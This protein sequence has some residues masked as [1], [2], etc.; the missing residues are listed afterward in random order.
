MTNYKN[1]NENVKFIYRDIDG[2]RQIRTE[3]LL[4]KIYYVRDKNGKDGISE[5]G[6]NLRMVNT[7]PL[8][9]EVYGEDVSDVDYTRLVHGITFANE[10]GIKLRTAIID[11]ETDDK[12]GFPNVKTA[13]KKILCFVLYDSYEKRY[14]IHGLENVSVDKLIDKINALNFK[15]FV[16][17]REEDM[18]S[19]LSKY[20]KNIDPDLLTGYNIDNFDVPYIINRAKR[21]KVDFTLN[22]TV[23]FDFEAGYIHIKHDEESYALDDVAKKELGY[24]KIERQEVWK[25]TALDRYFYCYWDV[26]IIIELDAKIGVLSYHEHLSVINNSH[27][28]QTFYPT[29]F[30][31]NTMITKVFDTPLKFKINLDKE[32][33]E[34]IDGGLV[35]EPSTG[36][37][38]NVMVFDI[39]GSYPSM[40]MTYNISP[41]TIIYKD[42]KPIGFRTDVK[43]VLPAVIEQ[44]LNERRR[45]KK[46]MKEEKDPIL[47]DGYDKYQ[48]AFKTVTNA[49]YGVFVSVKFAMFNKFLAGKIT[50][51]ARATIM[52]IKDFAETL[53]YIVLYGDTDSIFI[54]AK[55]KNITEEGKELA[56]KINDYI[57]EERKKQGLVNYT[58]IEFEKVFTKWLQTG[59]KKRYAGIY[60]KDNGEDELLIK[61]YE[62]RR[63]GNS[64]YTKITQ[65]EFIRLLLTDVALAKK[66]YKEEE[67]KWNEEKVSVYKIAINYAMRNN[68]EEYTTNLPVIRA[69]KNSRRK[70]I[71]I[72]ENLGR[73]WVYYLKNGEE[74]AFT[75]NSE[76]PHKLPID[77]KLHKDKCFTS[78][79]ESLY[80]LIG[81][82]TSL[83][84]FFE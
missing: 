25:M 67:R 2:K 64:L 39:S 61:G 62:V 55:T 46:L 20:F 22:N 30:I 34:N 13:D 1:D 37:F 83:N 14:Y 54:K 42:G 18:I 49:F 63:R 60:K 19:W 23:V 15:I 51:T 82:Q 78:P 47:R 12:D 11:I 72:D 33:K 65:R 32:R 52:M 10:E 74:I 16:H 4:K 36:I 56:N 44:M 28:S 27:I 77:Y 73:F 26:R 58:K 8:E 66:F 75:P 70:G 38:E 40:I 3:K 50:E 59:V 5:D 9:G 29:T 21:L 53:G 24:G 31:Y 69:V 41:E 81:E 48:Y 7:M 6:Y 57:K 45:V 35:F 84:S 68:I 79:L 17:K 43:G 76:I 80:A 71:K